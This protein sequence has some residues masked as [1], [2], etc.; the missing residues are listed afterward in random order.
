MSRRKKQSAEIGKTVLRTVFYMR[1]DCRQRM[2]DSAHLASSCFSAPLQQILY[3]GREDGIHADNREIACEKA[4]DVQIS[5]DVKHVLHF[6]PSADAVRERSVNA[7]RDDEKTQQPCQRAIPYGL[8]VK[9]HKAAEPRPKSRPVQAD[10]K[11][12]E[13]EHDKRRPDMQFVNGEIAG[14]FVRDESAEQE[15][16]HE[17]PRDDRQEKTCDQS[18][19]D[20]RTQDAG[21]RPFAADQGAEPAA[22]PNEMDDH[23]HRHEKSQHFVHIHPRQVQVEYEKKHDEQQHIE[24]NPFHVIHL[25]SVALPGSN[26]LFTYALTRKPVLECGCRRSAIKT[27]T[28]FPV[29]FRREF[30]QIIGTRADVAAA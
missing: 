1:F 21:R 23:G 26:D 9:M 13:N 2:T 22:V 20:R 17:N 15:M 29:G 3:R 6:K 12:D 4:D 8:R 10:M 19:I 11:T 7:A 16:R 30:V 18:G 25:L 14:K 5:A 24:D 27:L 28:V